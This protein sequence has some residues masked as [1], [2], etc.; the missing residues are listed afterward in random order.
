MKYRLF[1]LKRKIENV[2]IF[3]FILIGKLIGTF[4]TKKEDFEM[5]LIFPFYHTGGAEKVHSL[6]ANTLKNKKALILFT[7]KSKDKR[8][9]EAFKASGLKI[10]DISNYTDN[11][12]FYWNNLIYRG[13]IANLVNQQN[14]SP[15][16][17]NGQ[18]NFG[19][20]LSPWIKKEILQIELIHA[21][22]SFSWI[23]I[24]FI[25]YYSKTVMISRF[26]IN[27]HK[28]QYNKLGIPDK[29]L[30][31]IQYITNGIFIPS[32]LTRPVK[33]DNTLNILYVGRSTSEKRVN[34]IAQIAQ[35]ASLNQLDIKFSMVGDLKEFVQ[36]TY[37]PYIHFFGS[38]NNEEELFKIYQKHDV[39]I[40]TS[41]HEGFPISIMEAMSAGCAILSTP[42]GDIPYH[43]KHKQNGFLFSSTTDE[44]IIK[45][46]AI[47][48]LRDLMNEPSLLT[49]MSINNQQYAQ[50]E[51]ELSIFENRYQSLLN[52][53]K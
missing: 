30:N 28:E 26:A 11:K 35:Q 51:F 6:I 22:S 5:L 4:Y 52:Q 18:S 44:R 17:F 19:Y 8:Y 50:K 3:P 48:Y 32:N 40:I 13:I 34:L 25:Q 31:K 16:I 47:D 1:I 42:V 39:L 24:P 46:E 49:E 29:E 21:F 2:F 45:T 15:I 23:R 38:V 41:L 27:E 37:H 9:F 33:Q 7:R 20:K 53:T 36:S 43:V 14:R 12:F 10:I